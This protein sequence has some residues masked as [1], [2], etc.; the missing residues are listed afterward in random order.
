MDHDSRGAIRAVILAGGSGSRLWPLSR[1]QLPRQFLRFGGESPLMQATIERLQPLVGPSDILIVAS[2]EHAKGEAYRALLPYRSTL[3]PVARNLSGTSSRFGG[4]SR[5]S[6]S[7]CKSASILTKT[8]LSA[9][10]TAMA[11]A[12]REPESCHDA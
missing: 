9:S 11:G 3:E 6:S 8:T 7:R 12:D 1:Q 5:C 2:E 4:T 10:K